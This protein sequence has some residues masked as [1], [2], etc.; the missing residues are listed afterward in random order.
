M[1]CAKNTGAGSL[2]LLQ[3]IFPIQELNWGPLHF[4]QILYQLNYQGSPLKE[5]K[6]PECFVPLASRIFALEKADIAW[7]QI[8]F[9][10]VLW[11]IKPNEEII[12][13]GGETFKLPPLVSTKTKRC[14]THLMG[15][16]HKTQRYLLRLH[17][18]RD[19]RL[20]LHFSEGFQTRVQPQTESW[21]AIKP[22]VEF[23][24]FGRLDMPP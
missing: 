12:T 9:Q 21:G 4:R 17:W 6:L 8:A 1:F 18:S 16:T 10:T 14:D 5:K 22:G 24:Q 7:S 13:V 11:K 15:L 3:E 20:Y 23:I 19:Y 2:S